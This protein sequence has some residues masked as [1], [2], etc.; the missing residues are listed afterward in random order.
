[1]PDGV[2][3]KPGKGRRIVGG[4]HL[5]ATV[6]VTTGFPSLMS[7]FEMVIPPGYD[8]G[9]HVHELGEEIFYVLEGELDMFAFEP[10]D[11][12]VPDWHDWRSDDTNE[13]YMHGGPGTFMFVPENCPHAFGNPS[14]KP[15]R[16]FFQSSV[17]GGH[18]N[19]FV[20][21]A[22]LLSAAGGR[23]DRAASE[24]LRSRWH[25]VQLTAIGADLRRE[26][27]DALNA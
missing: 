5:D 2:M 27:T 24:E 8:V 12:S 26:R 11:R 1:M 10:I 18:E 19:Y 23:P 6:K 16:L 25:I 22:E 15:T 14:D 4:V 20:E 17:P 21:L 9:A 13:G 7:T 3:Y